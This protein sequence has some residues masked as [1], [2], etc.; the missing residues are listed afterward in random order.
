[1]PSASGMSALFGAWDTMQNI[2]NL[3]DILDHFDVPE[4]IWRAFELQV[5]SPGADLRLLAALPKVALITGCGGAVTPNGNLTPMEA[6]QVGLVWR[7]ARR[8]VAAQS[9]I[10]EAEF[11]DVDP[12][13][14]SGEAPGDTVPR[15]QG[16]RQ[17]TGVKEKVLKMNSLI[18]QQD[19]SELLP[20]PA[21]EVDR[22]YQ[23]YI[24]TMGAQPDETEEPTS[25][26][27]AALHK[28][29][30][31]ENRS[32]YC[33][34][35]VWVPFERRMSRVQKCRVYTPLGNG[36]FLQKDLPGPSTLMAWK[37][38][39]QVFRAACI[40]LNICTIA[41]LEAYSRQVEKLHVQWPRCW[42][43]I[44]MADDGARAERLEKMR[45]RLTIEAAQNRQVPREWDPMKPWSCVFTQ[46][47]NDLEY[48]T[49]RVHHPAASWTAAGGR[50]APTVATEAA[51]LEV[52]Q[53]GT[54]AMEQDGD[55]GNIA[56]DGRRAQAN[57]DKRQAKKRRMAADREELA[58]HRSST[59]S[60]SKGSGQSKGKGKGKSKDQ[61]GQ[62]LCFSWSSGRGPCAEV[63][64]GGECKAAV[65]R[66]HKCRLCLS[67]A[68]RDSDC[69]A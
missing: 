50:G 37:A 16:Q 68:H 4:R 15:E 44:Y 52:I 62:E 28:R 30:Y 2:R 6:T 24:V 40:M 55:Q 32:P 53:G 8:V 56:G 26:Q 35:S 12:W 3:D 23:N 43:L 22:W 31:I 29:V 42:G 66:I 48:W 47:A 63:A 10:S 46:L 1:M 27:L 7:M 41:S 61:T 18:D 45:R 25:A 58:R 64:P 14:E 69:K 21:T 34:F 49:D 54:K 36:S 17:S 59:T 9:N 20:P 39:W 38:S 13:M 33:D 5:G 11:V 57:R 51:V 67:P 65:K 60:G 19:E